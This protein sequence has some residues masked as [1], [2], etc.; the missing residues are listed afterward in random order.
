MWMS[1]AWLILPA[2]KYVGYYLFKFLSHPIGLK[3][4]LRYIVLKKGY[5]T[6]RRRI[7]LLDTLKSILIYLS[8]FTQSLILFIISTLRAVY[9]VYF[10]TQVRNHCTQVRKTGVKIALRYVIIALRYV[11]Y[12]QSLFSVNTTLGSPVEAVLI[13]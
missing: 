7:A 1:I 12:S 3:I 5:P 10:C 8:I 9:S 13:S 6:V 4:T 11:V 2:P